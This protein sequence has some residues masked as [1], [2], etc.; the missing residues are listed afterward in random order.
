MYGSLNQADGLGEHTYA[1]L[2]KAGSGKNSNRSSD[3]IN[4]AG[5]IAMT[6]PV[7]TGGSDRSGTEAQG[8]ISR[9]KTIGPQMSTPQELVK[10][11]R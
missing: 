8:V 10:V 5:Y 1:S 3:N 7:P 2:N 9:V 4:N 6:A 11:E